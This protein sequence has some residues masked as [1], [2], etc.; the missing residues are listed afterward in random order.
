LLSAAVCCPSRLCSIGWTGIA[1]TALAIVPGGAGALL[2]TRP[3]ATQL[4]TSTSTWLSCQRF[5][6][7]PF[8]EE[9]KRRIGLLSKKKLQKQSVFVAFFENL[10]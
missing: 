6:P 7:L 5:C 4:A 3:F 2:S 9:A 1:A 10:K 8:F